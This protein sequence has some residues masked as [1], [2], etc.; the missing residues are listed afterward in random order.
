MA[1]TEEQIADVRRFAGYALPG[2]DIIIDASRDFAYG[3]VAPGVYQT[4]FTLLQNLRPAAESILL[5]NYLPT[6]NKMEREL[7]EA[8]ANMDTL[9]A[10][11]WKWNTNEFSDRKRLF[12]NKRR[13]MCE[14]LG[15]NPGPGLKGGG[16]ISR[17]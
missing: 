13:R 17:A 8:G 10:G 15:I 5:N 11:V 16:R 9:E 1:L 3:W 6:L 14:Q 2:A 12:N 4:L 7:D